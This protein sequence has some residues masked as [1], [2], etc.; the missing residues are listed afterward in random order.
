MSTEV[1]HGCNLPWSE[2]SP[3]CVFNYHKK[4]EVAPNTDLVCNICNEKIGSYCMLSPDNS[5]L[6]MMSSSVI[7]LREHFRTIHSYNNPFPKFTMCT[8]CHKVSEFLPEQKWKDC[9]HTI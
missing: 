2:E 1:C 8:Y 9:G 6:D 7:A 3:N 5:L 4:P